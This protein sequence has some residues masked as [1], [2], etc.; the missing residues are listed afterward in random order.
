MSSITPTP[1]SIRTAIFAALRGVHRRR[2]QLA[3][4][5]AAEAV[6]ERRAAEPV[7]VGDLDHRH[8]GVVEGGD[9][10]ANIGFGELVTIGMGAVAQ[11]R[12]G[13][14][15]V[16]VRRKSSCHELPGASGRS[17]RRPWSRPRS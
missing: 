9:H 4:V 15:N 12:I 14:A 3:F 8:A 6:R 17:P 13:D 2:D 5:G 11:R 10:G 1:G 7:T 16:D